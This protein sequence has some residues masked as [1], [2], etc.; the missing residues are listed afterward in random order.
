MAMAAFG[1]VTTVG[2]DI[3][4]RVH[5][6]VAKK[7]RPLASIA[8]TRKLTIMPSK[9]KEAFSSVVLFHGEDESVLAVDFA[10]SVESAIA[11]FDGYYN[12]GLSPEK[13]VEVKKEDLWPDT[14]R[15]GIQNISDDE[16]RPI[17]RAVWHFCNSNKRGAQD[18][19]TWTPK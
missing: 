6:A 19:W 4:F 15:F 13:R 7:A 12:E 2:M 11:I 1:R 8:R 10:M 17:M 14:V 5:I 16:M 3:G 9:F 18:V